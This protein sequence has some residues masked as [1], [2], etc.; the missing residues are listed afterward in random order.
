MVLSPRARAGIGSTGRGLCHS[1][2]HPLTLPS[3]PGSLVGTDAD[4]ASSVWSDSDD[5][6]SAAGWLGGGA[7]ADRQPASAASS[8]S[9]S[10]LTPD[11]AASGG[12]VP[13]PD[14][15]VPQGG[16]TARDQLLQ[17]MQVSGLTVFLCAATCWLSQSAANACSMQQK[18]ADSQRL[19]EPAAACRV[20]CELLCTPRNGCTDC[21]PHD[22][23]RV[24]AERQRL[25][26]QQAELLH[27]LE[28]AAASDAAAEARPVLQAALAEAR[29]VAGAE[30]QGVDE[31]L[32]ALQLQVG[33]TWPLAVPAADL[34]CSTHAVAGSRTGASVRLQVES[35]KAKQ[36]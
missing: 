12:P 9:V 33:S 2:L 25:A 31:R 32:A 15:D 20:G 34:S 24:D 4:A 21:S 19:M 26:V 10:G 17:Q 6:P 29:A 36:S 35:A 27:G 16:G 14:S 23:Q 30:Q 8:P 5:E 28:A 22:N 7:S 13:Q 11:G 3:S 1:I 18:P